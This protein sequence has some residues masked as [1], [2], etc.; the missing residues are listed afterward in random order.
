MVAHRS[1]IERPLR[2]QN[3]SDVI[4]LDVVSPGWAL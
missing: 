2:T 3:D 4:R 1:H